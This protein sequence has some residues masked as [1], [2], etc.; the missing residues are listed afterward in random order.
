MVKKLELLNEQLQRASS[1]EAKLSLLDAYPVV[2]KYLNRNAFVRNYLNQLPLKYQVICKQLIAIEQMER[3]IPKEAFNTSAF[4]TFLDQMSAIDS[5]Y[6]ELGG[7]V[8]YQKTVLD[9]LCSFTRHET[10]EKASFYSPDFVDITE[11]TPTVLEAIYTG[12]NSL[13]Q[14]AEM[15]PLGG[16]A[17][18]LHL[19]DPKTQQELPAAKLNYAGKTLLEGLIRDLQA[20]EYLYFKLHGTQVT[21]PIA[22]MTSQEKNNHN[23]VLHICETHGWFGRQKEMFHL[24]LQPLVP[25]VDLNGNWCFVDSCSPLLKPGGHGA[26]WKLARDFGVFKWLQDLTKKNA[27]IRQINNP[28]AAVDYGLLAFTGW[29]IQKKSVFGFASCPRIVFSS[30]GMNVIIKQKNGELVLTNIEY[31]DFAKFGIEDKP[32]KEGEPYSRFTS[33][34]NILFADLEAVEAAVHRCPF[35]GLL[36]NLKQIVYGAFSEKTPK[37]V[38]ARLESTMQNIADAFT[39]NHQPDATFVTYNHR[40]KTIATAKKAYT[41]GGPFQETPEECFYIQLQNGRELL[42][43]KCRFILPHPAR[44]FSDYLEKGPD[45][46]FIYHPALGPLYSLIHQKI[47][48]G[49]IAEGSELQLEI[50]DL[51]IVNLTLEGSLII[52]A[53]HPL[54][55][56]DK[57]GILHYSNQTGRCILKNVTVKNQGVDWKSSQPYWKNQFTRKGKL[58]IRLNGF[59]EF[60]A[61]G[62]VFSRDFCVDVPPNIRMRVTQKQEE[63]LITKEPLTETPFWNYQWEKRRG[64]L[65]VR[66]NKSPQL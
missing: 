4:Y 32:L 53:S 31:C 8:G 10:T 18:R 13:P 58:E 27:L 22:I 47:H 59:S 21:V 65:A 24:F 36:L 37:N 54:G 28:I 38:T 6:H 66:G 60:V 1:V 39:Q 62:V 42:E 12:I 40:N 48:S 43:K 46:V 17:D 34:T 7:I 44:S 45:M 51:Q 16:A 14:M 20:R 11:E 55:H 50:V 5:F 30:E 9:F 61:E 29:G 15:Y 56:F 41:A 26:L 57:H 49:K 64:V 35:P 2:K 25:T 52:H 33:N 63:L 19:L 3:L 23:H